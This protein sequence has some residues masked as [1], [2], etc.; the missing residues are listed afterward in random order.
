MGDRAIAALVRL[1]ARD[2]EGRARRAAARERAGDAARNGGRG[3]GMAC[4]FWR[5]CIGCLLLPH[6]W[7]QGK[8]NGCALRRVLVA[9]LVVRQTRPHVETGGGDGVGYRSQV[10]VA[11]AWTA[12]GAMRAARVQAIARVHA[13]VVG[14]LPPWGACVAEQRSLLRAPRALFRIGGRDSTCTE[15][16]VCALCDLCIAACLGC[17]G[18]MWREL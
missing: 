10:R 7:P 9:S 17:C 18:G 3:R 14:L 15:L 16:Q 8:P 1:N 6:T 2:G 5:A 13:I 4:S 11:Q 12:R